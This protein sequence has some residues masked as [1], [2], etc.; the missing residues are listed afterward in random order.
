MA[1]IIQ[2]THIRAGA[3]VRFPAKVARLFE[4]AGLSLAVHRPLTPA[5]RE[6]VQGW[7]CSEITSGLS[8][9]QFS[10]DT[11][12]AAESYA[13]ERIDQSEA[14]KRGAIAQA[15]AEKIAEYGQANDPANLAD[16]KAPPVSEYKA[17]L[18]RALEIID[19]AG[20]FNGIRYESEFEAWRALIDA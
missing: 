10:Q 14:F 3:A 13:R 9:L 1:K 11:I 20:S 2:T 16:A 6:S 7:R 15:I 17:A 12:T 18:R 8:I 4:H 5:G 19:G